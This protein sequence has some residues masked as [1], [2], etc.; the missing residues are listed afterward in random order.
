[1]IAVRAVVGLVQVEDVLVAEG[2]LDGASTNLDDHLG[3]AVD[4]DVI[5]T[6]PPEDEPSRRLTGPFLTR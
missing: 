6:T 2:D 5:A 4:L 3:A 1:M